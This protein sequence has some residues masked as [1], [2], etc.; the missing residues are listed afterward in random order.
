LHTAKAGGMSVGKHV[1]EILQVLLGRR[2]SVESWEWTGFHV[3]VAAIEPSGHST[4]IEV[5]QI[6]LAVTY[7][8]MIEIDNTSRSYLPL[9]VRTTA[10]HVADGSV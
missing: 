1:M 2:R 4:S 5:F 8:E 10:P 9:G 3:Y 7:F 6:Q